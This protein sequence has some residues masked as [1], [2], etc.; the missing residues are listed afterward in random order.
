MNDGSDTQER[1]LKIANQYQAGN[2]SMRT[3]AQQ[4]GLS[5]ARIGQILDAAHIN[6][7]RIQK[8]RQVLRTQA[9]K[10][11]WCQRRFGVSLAVF[12]R[13]RDIDIAI[14]RAGH[15]L[16]I[17]RMYARDKNR[18]KR[19]GV[20]WDLNLES[21]SWLWS[22]FAKMDSGSANKPDYQ[23]GRLDLDG[24]FDYSNTV[25]D[26]YEASARQPRTAKR[27]KNSGLPMGV[28][29]AGEKFVAVL[30]DHN[31]YRRIGPFFTPE[32]ASRAYQDAIAA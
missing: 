20:A 1:D 22:D 17:T 12:L 30:R 10:E 4:H 28:R 25:I 6:P 19:D 16:T 26:P 15:A 3:L 13:V 29:R 21:Y 24:D 23:L 7:K 5:H 11:T 27:Q 2:I 32:Q 31:C 14:R 8:A 9:E 18:A